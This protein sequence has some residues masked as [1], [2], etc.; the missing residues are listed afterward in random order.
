MILIGMFDSPYTRRVAISATLLG[1]PFEHRNWS[2]G[3]D[4]DRIRAYNPLGR[5]PVL[6]LDDGQALI[7]SSIIVDYLDQLAGPEHALLPAGGPTR[8]QTQTILAIATGAV[9][10][11]IHVVIERVFRPVDKHH[12]AWTDRCRAQVA[13]ACT[14]LERVCA[15]RADREWLVADAITQADITLACFLTYLREAM[16]LDLAAY[17]ALEQRVQHYE[18]RP[19]FSRFHVPFEAPV[20]VGVCAA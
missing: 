16:P 5:V 1:I 12:A 20:S 18:S 14:E 19:A 6:V 13:G 15:S 9:D 2:V 8:L 3:S 17:P 11:G 4:F 7:E 10:K